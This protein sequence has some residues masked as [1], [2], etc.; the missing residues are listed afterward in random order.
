MESKGRIYHFSTVLGL[1]LTCVLVTTSFGSLKMIDTDAAFPRTSSPRS[2]SSSK[3]VTGTH[4]GNATWFSGIGS[5]TYGGCGVPPANLD[6][7][8]YVALNVQ[9]DPGD[10]STMLSRPIATKYAKDIGMF[11]NGL[12]CGRWVKVTIG[13]KCL[14]TNDGAP[15]KPFC[16]G[17]SWAADQ[18]NGA[19]LNMV[20]ADS[21]QDGNAWCRDDPYHLDLVQRS[22]N[23]FVLHSRPVG[24]MYPNAWNNRH[25]SW[26]LISAPNYTGDIKIAFLRGANLY[27]S[28]ISVTHLANGIH[29][30]RYY[31]NG[32]WVR[33]SMDSD[34][35][36]DYVIGPTVTGGSRYQIQVYDSSDKLINKGRIYSFSYPTS[37]GSSCSAE[38]LPIS[39]TKKVSSPKSGAVSLVNLGHERDGES[40]LAKLPQSIEMIRFGVYP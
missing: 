37:C 5:G 26:Q 16:H 39:Y 7:K 2:A 35:G 19:T 32:T 9:N 10:Y 30:I 6:S 31:Q 40:S 23:Q 3:T 13:D 12:N 22:L 38:Y 24:N 4:I 28:A 8:Y 1:L 15:N 20:V 21:C 33:A 18:Y 17:G 27:W 14:G 11:N 29:G 34:M 36:N 25:I